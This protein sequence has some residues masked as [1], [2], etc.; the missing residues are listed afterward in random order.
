MEELSEKD[1]YCIAKHIQEFVRTVFHKEK[2]PEV[3]CYDCRFNK[4]CAKNECTHYDSFGRLSD[5]TGVKISP[6]KG[7]KE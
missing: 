3:A 2:D 7:F 4:E 1:L 6:L 5:I